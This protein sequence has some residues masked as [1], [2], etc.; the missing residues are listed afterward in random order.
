MTGQDPPPE[1]LDTLLETDLDLL[2]EKLTDIHPE[3]VA[4][5]IRN[6]DGIARRSCSRSCPPNMPPKCSSGWS[7]DQQEE[8]AERIDIGPLTQLTLE[9]SADDRVDFLSLVPGPSAGTCCAASKR[10]IRKSS[11]TSRS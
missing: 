7:Q 9:M 11:K 1:P 2:R 4:D 3:D 10:R 5:L 8:I 6:V